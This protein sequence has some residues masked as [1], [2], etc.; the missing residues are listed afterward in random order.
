MKPRKQ[1]DTYPITATLMT[2]T[3]PRDL[4]GST[5]TIYTR[6]AGTKV[7][8]VNGASVT[9]TSVSGGTISY[10][11]TGA[12]V[13]TPGVYDLEFRERTSGGQTIDYPSHGFERL[14]IEENIS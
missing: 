13:D 2:G 4:T 14:V 11:P 10:T 5:V 1:G 3:V 12:D 9:I 8:K 6:D 7:I